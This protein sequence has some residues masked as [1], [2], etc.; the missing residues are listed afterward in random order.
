L[1]PAW[2]YGLSGVI[3][4]PESTRRCPNEVSKFG[5]RGTSG[6]PVIAA[7]GVLPAPRE[8]CA[9][10]FRVRELIAREEGDRGSST[11]PGG[12]DP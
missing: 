7:A 11:R 1:H 9:L 2:T 4:F 12:R 10:G 8:G 6:A 5:A 3:A